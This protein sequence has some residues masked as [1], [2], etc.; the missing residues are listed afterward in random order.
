MKLEHSKAFFQ[1]QRNGKQLNFV[2][3]TCLAESLGNFSE[4]H[5]FQSANAFLS[6][7]D[8][9]RKKSSLMCTYMLKLLI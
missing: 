6:F 8:V 9:S 2:N 3:R 1:K 5:S 7:G 4:M